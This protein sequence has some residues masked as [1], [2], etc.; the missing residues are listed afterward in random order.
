MKVL[1]TKPDSCREDTDPPIYQNDVT[2][3]WDGSQLYGS[4]IETHKRVRS[5]AGGKLIVDDDDGLLPVDPKTNID[6]TGKTLVIH[7]ER[8]SLIMCLV[9]IFLRELIFSG[10]KTHHRSLFVARLV[11][12]S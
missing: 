4:D 12:V 9:Q 10:L 2:H 6:V 1:R 5:F 3:W 8:H 11:L 7:H